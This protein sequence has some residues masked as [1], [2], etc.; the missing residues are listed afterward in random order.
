MKMTVGNK[1]FKKRASHL[2]IYESG[3]SKAQINN[4]LL[5]RNQR[6]F[7]KDMKTLPSEECITRHKPLVCEFMIKIVKDTKT[8]L[9]PRR[10]I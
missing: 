6:K 2:V 9:V 10:K 1:L 7:F 4:Y 5:R 3:P 8:K